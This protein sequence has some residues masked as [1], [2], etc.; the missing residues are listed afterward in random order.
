MSSDFLFDHCALS[1]YL[2]RRVVTSIGIHGK[3]CGRGKSEIV[4]GKLRNM[5]GSC[6][7]QKCPKGQGAAIPHEV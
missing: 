6:P 1:R 7:V 2:R 5:V 3:E 4:S